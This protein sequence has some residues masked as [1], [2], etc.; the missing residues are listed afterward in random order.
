MNLNK[1]ELTT[2]VEWLPSNIEEFK[3]KNP[4]EVVMILNEMSQTDEGIDIISN[5]INQ[6]K[7]RNQ[8]FEKGGKLN[9]LVE[10]LKNGNKYNRQQARQNKES[11]GLYNFDEETG[12]KYRKTID[13]GNLKAKIAKSKAVDGYKDEDFIDSFDRKDFRQKKQ[14]LKK[15]NPNMSRRERK[16]EALLSR[17]KISPTIDPEKLQ[18]FDSGISYTFPKKGI[19]SVGDLTE[20]VIPNPITSTKNIDVDPP[21]ITMP[22][23]PTRNKLNWNEFAHAIETRLRNDGTFRAGM[24][25]SALQALMEDEYKRYYE[26]PDSYKF[27]NYQLQESRFNKYRNRSLTMPQP[28]YRTGYGDF[29]QDTSYLF[30]NERM[31]TIPSSNSY[32][33]M[34]K[35]ISYPIMASIAATAAAPVII[36]GA[37]DAIGYA[38]QMLKNAQTSGYYP[39]QIVQRPSN[40]ARVRLPNG[41][42]TQR[43]AQELYRGPQGHYVAPYQVP[44]FFFKTGGEISKFDNGGKQRRSDQFRKEFH[45]VDLFK[46]GPNSRQRINN[47]FDGTSVPSG[48]NSET[49]PN[50]VGIRQISNKN[51]TT[52]ELVSPDKKDTLYIHNGVAGRVDSNID[53]SG[54]LGFFGL[55]KSS[56]ISDRY[57]FLQKVFKAHKF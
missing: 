17:P 50:G 15:T 37:R 49:L 56:P 9:F 57:K 51:I 12:Q 47:A 30:N 39:R 31:R 4:E 11:A 45:G 8:M 43:P 41:Q 38:G 23:G 32:E 18:K 6:F 42:Y 1:Q 7:E 28:I 19:V 26:N 54:I 3:D 21:I 34:T 48:S 53:D 55:K 36:Q 46:Y 5:L 35:S 16:A 2:F 24:D 27:D 20:E 29:D 25:M 14:A 10:K 33:V 52:T 13:K 44:N 40:P 22:T